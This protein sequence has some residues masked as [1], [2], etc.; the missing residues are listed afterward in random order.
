MAK[1][2]HGSSDE[3]NQKLLQCLKDV[4]EVEAWHLLGEADD[5]KEKSLR[6]FVH[7][8]PNLASSV[9]IPLASSLSLY[10]NSFS[11]LFPKRKSIYENARKIFSLQGFNKVINLVSLP[12][13]NATSSS[14]ATPFLWFLLR[15]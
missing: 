10:L 2:D 5:L 1:S 13:Q 14:Y 15:F 12:S 8:L 7:T 11:T 4:V 3:V 9:F 6:R